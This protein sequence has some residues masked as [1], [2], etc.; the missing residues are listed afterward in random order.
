M[1]AKFISE[2]IRFEKDLDPKETMRIGKDRFR[3]PGDEDIMAGIVLRDTGGTPSKALVNLENG[4][5]YEI[6]LFALKETIRAIKEL[7]G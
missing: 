4:K 2:N 1:K 6:P 5:M 3:Q 7:F